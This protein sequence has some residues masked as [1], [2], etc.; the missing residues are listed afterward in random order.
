MDVKI[1]DK[2]QSEIKDAGG[3]QPYLQRHIALIRSSDVRACVRARIREAVPVS[4]SDSIFEIVP[5]TILA[6][7]HY[8]TVTVKT[9]S[10]R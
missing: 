2:G 3:L 9:R 4:G 1:K 7:S 6:Q 8:R 10:P 5:I